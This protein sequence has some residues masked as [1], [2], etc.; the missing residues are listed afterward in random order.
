MFAMLRKP[1]RRALKARGYHLKDV[2]AP[3]RRPLAFFAATRRRGLEVGTVIDVGVGNGTDWLM[4]AFPATYTVLVEPNEDFRP[5]IDDIL[6]QRPGEAHFFASGAAPGEARFHLNAKT[7]TSSS[8]LAASD[9]QRAEKDRRGWAADTREMVVPVRRLDS[10]E[11]SAWPKPYLLKL[12]V[13][14]FELEVLKGA[15]ALLA[16]TALIVAEIGV[17]QRH[18]AEPSF[19]EVIAAMDG[20]GFALFDIVGLTQFGR[21]GRLA[22]IDGVFVPKDSPLARA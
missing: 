9:E 20:H 13:E 5:A 11:R 6:A 7:P 1:L 12:D 3:L 10:L 19:A 8:L 17:A 16:D 18:A 21:D 14:G 4:R 22:F 2:D 15:G